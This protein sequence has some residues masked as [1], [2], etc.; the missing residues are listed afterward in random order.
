[1]TFMVKVFGCREAYENR[2][3]RN[4]RGCGARYGDFS[5]CLRRMTTERRRDGLEGDA[6]SESFRRAVVGLGIG[7]QGASRLLARS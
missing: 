7:R 3:S 6:A 4:P 2:P 1:M 5:I